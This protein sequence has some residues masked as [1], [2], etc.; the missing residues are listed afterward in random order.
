MPGLGPLRLIADRALVGKQTTVDEG[1]MFVGDSAVQL[2]A[3]YNRPDNEAPEREAL[4]TAGVHIALDRN[5]R[6]ARQE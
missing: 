5:I 1:L 2:R 3:R 4:A 6:L